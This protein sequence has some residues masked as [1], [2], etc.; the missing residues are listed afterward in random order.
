MSELEKILKD[1]LY[2]GVGAVATA[3]EKTGEL[4]KNLV[5]KGAQVLEDNRDQ[6]DALKQKGKAALDNVA[7]RFTSLVDKLRSQTA[8]KAEDPS[9]TEETVKEELQELDSLEVELRKVEDILRDIQ[10][11]EAEEQP[12]VTTDAAEACEAAEA[13]EAGKKPADCLDKVLDDAARPVEEFIQ[14]VGEPIEKMAQKAVDF[15]N[16]DEMRQTADHLMEEGDRLFQRVGQ[17]LESA[18]QKKPEIPDTE[19]LLRSL[20]DRLESFAQRLEAGRKALDDQRKP[21]DQGK[22]PNNP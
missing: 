12:A 1:V 6:T 9:P 8:P 14:N 19:A 10:E 21:E 5:N 11:P 7:A 18:T 15:L 16:T 13:A 4:A 17:A 3:V 2:G 20:Q 22:N